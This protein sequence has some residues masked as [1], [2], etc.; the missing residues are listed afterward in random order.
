LPPPKTLPY[1]QGDPIPPGY[2]L[3]TRARR[4]LVIA[5]AVTFGSTY[6]ASALF[7]GAFLAEGGD[8]GSMFGPLLIPI[9]G[10]FVTIG[11]SESEGIGTFL[12]V[13][14]GVFQA[15]GGAL[16][17]AGF[18]AEEE[19]LDRTAVGSFKLTPP[20]LIVGPGSAALRW[21]F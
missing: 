15:A 9:A 2:E 3:K 12:L 20:S 11:T 10:P 13:L 17:V 1:S 14:D 7:G 6:V 4:G 19:Y 8:V 16:F 21:R 5:G 18:L